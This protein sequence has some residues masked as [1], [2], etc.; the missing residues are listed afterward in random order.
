MSDNRYY[1]GGVIDNVLDG[2]HQHL[3]ALAAAA[4]AAAAAGA[5][6][7]DVEAAIQKLESALEAIGHGGPPRVYYG[8]VIHNTLDSVRQ[9]LH[10]LHGAARRELSSSGDRHTA[11]SLARLQSALEALG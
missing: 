7:E 1:Y 6:E 11:D 8:V 3:H 2:V 4:R 5:V 9:Q 10:A